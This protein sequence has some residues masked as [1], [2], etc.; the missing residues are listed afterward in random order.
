MGVPSVPVDVGQWF[1]IPVGIRSHP[2]IAYSLTES[3]QD[4]P[5]ASVASFEL[6]NENNTII[7]RPG[8]AMAIDRENLDPDVTV[9]RDTCRSECSAYYFT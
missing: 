7:S 2:R 3:V 4:S 5:K 8:S 6:D 1:H 9:G